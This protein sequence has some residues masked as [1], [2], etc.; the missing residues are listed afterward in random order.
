[1]GVGLFCTWLK[2][3]VALPYVHTNTCNVLV[4]AWFW[5]AVTFSPGSKLTWIL[6]FSQFFF[7]CFY[8]A[9][10]YYNSYGRWLCEVYPAGFPKGPWP[11]SGCIGAQG[12]LAVW[13]ALH[14]AGNLDDLLAQL[15]GAYSQPVDDLQ[16]PSTSKECLRIVAGKSPDC[17]GF[18]S[19]CILRI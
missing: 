5:K 3:G 10:L 8:Y 14:D 2:S 18:V 4:L 1:M 13:E 9:L 16:S 7:F 6:V 15:S 19:I 11:P 12:S 17:P